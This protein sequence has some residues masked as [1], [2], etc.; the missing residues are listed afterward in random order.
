MPEPRNLGQMV[1]D[2]KLIHSMSEAR[3]LAVT[4][5]ITVNGEVV[6]SIEALHEITPCD[7][8]SIRVGQKTLQVV[9]IPSPAEAPMEE[10]PREGEDRFTE[11][12]PGVVLTRSEL[13]GILEVMGQLWRKIPDEQKTPVPEWDNLCERFSV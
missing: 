3:R 12:D 6:T 5:G 11:E 8:D 13:V 1:T 4:G 7:G 2:S 9:Q 10:F